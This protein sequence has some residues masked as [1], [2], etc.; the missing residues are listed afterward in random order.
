LVHS[1]KILPP[2]E[3]TNDLHLRY[4]I[5]KDNTDAFKII[6]GDLSVIP[7]EKPLIIENEVLKFFKWIEQVKN[8]FADRWQEENNWFTDAFEYQAKYPDAKGIDKSD[9]SNPYFLCERIASKAEL[10]SGKFNVDE[11]NKLLINSGIEPEI[12]S[13]VYSYAQECGGGLG[14]RIYT[15]SVRFRPTWFA[16][17]V[18]TNMSEKTIILESLAGAYN[19]T[20]N[21]LRLYEDS[22]GEESYKFEFPKAGIDHGQS[23]VI[24]CGLLFAPLE[25]LNYEQ[26]VI[27]S[28]HSNP[29][30]IKQ[31]SITDGIESVK[32]KFTSL[33]QPLNLHF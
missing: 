6:N 22:S 19:G 18:V 32:N 27:Y 23:V 9:P 33:G 15:E 13:R 16:F 14:D 29:E 5:C 20:V 12:I 1:N 26:R 3:W 30:V 31:F 7:V 11:L 17:M 24:P 8:K 2:A 4:L 25:N 10:L 28:N 21:A